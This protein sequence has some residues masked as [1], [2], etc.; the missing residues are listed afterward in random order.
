MSY[1]NIIMFSAVIPSFDSDNKKEETLNADDPK[2]R[3][4]I[5]RILSEN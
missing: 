5:E 3:K 1:A 2:N 4:E